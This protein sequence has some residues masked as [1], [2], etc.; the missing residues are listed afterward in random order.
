MLEI[1]KETNS[2]DK[3]VEIAFSR[4]EKL[5]SQIAKLKTSFSKVERENLEAIGIDIDKKYYATFREEDTITKYTG[6]VFLRVP[7]IIPYDAAK[8]IDKMIRKKQYNKHIPYDT[9]KKDKAAQGPYE[10]MCYSSYFKIIKK[11]EEKIQGCSEI[12]LGG[13][14]TDLKEKKETI[15]LDEIR[16]HCKCERPAFRIIRPDTIVYPLYGGDYSNLLNLDGRIRHL[17]GADLMRNMDILSYNTRE[18]RKSEKD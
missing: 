17:I 14:N 4:L 2:P 1:V 16:N 9:E 12:G 18:K 6:Y 13:F 3:P 15:E 11:T 5:L 10:I 7:I 8:L